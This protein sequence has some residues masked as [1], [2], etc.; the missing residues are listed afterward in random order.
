MNGCIFER[1]SVV[2][3][4]LEWGLDAVIQHVASISLSWPLGL[5]DDAIL[6]ASGLWR[7]DAVFG[8]L[9]L[10]RVMVALDGPQHLTWRWRDIYGVSRMIRAVVVTAGRSKERVHRME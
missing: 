4:W 5:A 6:R 2:P 1:A 9:R 7:L 8:V 3:V 10:L